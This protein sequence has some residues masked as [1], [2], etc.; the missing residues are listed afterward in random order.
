[1]A[2]ILLVLHVRLLDTVGKFGNRDRI[3]YFVP[4]LQKHNF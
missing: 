3:K 1:M 4:F 2:C